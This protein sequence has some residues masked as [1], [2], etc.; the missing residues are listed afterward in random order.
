MRSYIRRPCGHR[1]RT[2]DSQQSILSMEVIP[3]TKQ[4]IYS[5]GM[6][7]NYVVSLLVAFVQYV[8]H[9]QIEAQGCN[10]DTV[11]YRDQQYWCIR[12]YHVHMLLFIS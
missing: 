11:V 12:I 10:V 5:M 3:T 7:R 9:P 1:L 2:A 8:T 4:D 6:C